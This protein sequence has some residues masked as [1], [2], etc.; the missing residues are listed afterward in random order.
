[1]RIVVKNFAE[2]DYLL[3]KYGRWKRNYVVGLGYPSSS[4]ESQIQS[5]EIFGDGC[6]RGG[7]KP[8]AHD[9]NFREDQESSYINRC[10][11][12]MKKT[13]TQEMKVLDLVYVCDWSVKQIAKEV[14]S[15]RYQ[16]YQ[17]LRRSKTL[18]EGWLIRY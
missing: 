18:L 8:G 6:R 3:E 11:N 12:Q 15:S 5:G 9:P 4:I 17:L 16:V 1:M 7:R 10:I 13:H 2:L 14:G